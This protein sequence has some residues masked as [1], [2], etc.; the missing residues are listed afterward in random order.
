MS[1]DAVVQRDW[2]DRSESAAAD[3]GAASYGRYG[4]L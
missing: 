3:Y 2:M 1:Q 4:S